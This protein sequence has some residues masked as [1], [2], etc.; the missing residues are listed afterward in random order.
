VFIIVSYLLA[1][2]VDVVFYSHGFSLASTQA[3]TSVF[4]ILWGFARMWSVALAVV[5]CLKLQKERV[6]DW[7]RGLF[8]F[9]KKTVALYLFSPLLVYLALGIYVLL[10]LPLG[11][12]DFNA[13]VNIVADVIKSSHAG[14]TSQDAERLA[15]L[16]AF[17]Q[18]PQAYL[19]AITINALFALGEE[20]GWR[21][22]LYKMLGS[23]PSFRN[24]ALIGASWG[25][26][27]ASAIVLLGFNYTYNRALGALLFML[28]CIAFTYPH[29]IVVSLS[30][31]VLPAA[32]L[33][34]AINALWGLTLYASSVP[35]ERGEIVLGLG[36]LGTATWSVLSL[37]TA[38]VTKSMGKVK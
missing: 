37:L 2:M 31:S 30:N 16:Y 1:L 36:F 11:Y 24:V 20:I 14:V 10:A 15:R 5:L 32:S 38:L 3:T 27:H 29:L 34:G 25:L 35:R 26:W 6:R 9:N 7:L 33:H 22:Y 13:Y 4:A 23:R 19:F 18:I 17:A 21:A 8:R 28:L 12:F